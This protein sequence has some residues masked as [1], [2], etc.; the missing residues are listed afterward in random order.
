MTAGTGPQ[1]PEDFR[2]WG[3]RLSNWGRWGPLDQLGTLN[4]TSPAHVAAAARLVQT[5]RVVSLG[6]PLDADGPQVPGGARS[7]PVHVMTRTGAVTPE[8]GG[9]T[10]MD[11]LLVL[12]PQGATQIDALAHVGYD[13][14]L[15]NGVPVSSVGAAGAERLGV[16]VIAA[17]VHGRGVLLD[18]PRSLGVDR[19]APDHEITP[20]QLGGCARA[21]GLQVGEGDVVLVR[22]GWMQQLHE[23][24]PRAYLEREPGLGLAA[25]AW[26]VERRV[27]FLASDNWGVEVAPGAGDDSMPVHCVLVRDV[28]MPL[29]EMFDLEELAR[30]CAELGRWEFF[31]AAHPLRITGGTGSPLE[32]KA[33]L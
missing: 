24:G 2:A 13:G 19:L 17:G 33:L 3:Q 26:L 31:F 25:A 9:F 22:T 27:A 18:V 21:Q 28:G 16:E 8:P 5:G 30:A 20:D 10:W 12:Y 15:Y 32:P 23:H 14:L 4:W 1:P 6:L 11:D 29:G 7:N